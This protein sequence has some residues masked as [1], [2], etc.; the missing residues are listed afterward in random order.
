MKNKETGALAIE[1]VLSLT[2]FML[3]VIS[4]MFMA[5]II[6][7]QANMQYALS[8]TAKEISGYF[9]LVDKIGLT[10]VLSGAS[11][12]EVNEQVAEVNETI[13]NFSVLISNTEDLGSSIVSADD[14]TD[15]EGI[16][17]QTID[18]KDKAE[19]LGGQ[20]IEDIKNGE[21]KNQVIAV[22]KVFAKTMINKGFSYYVTPYVCKAL[23]PKYLTSGNINDYCAS[24][25]LKWNQNYDEG[26]E[27][28]MDFSGSQLLLDGRSVKLDVVYTINTKPLTFGLV[29]TNIAFHQC[30]TTAAWIKP[31]GGSLK[32]LTEVYR[33]NNLV[34]PTKP[35]GS[36]DEGEIAEE[37]EGE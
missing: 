5:V 13:D 22:L 29:D 26:V 35:E 37:G 21:A 33:A 23:L 27:Q 14:Y 17:N 18:I 36:G 6:K 9:Y 1:T 7:V 32:T 20:L 31:N 15:L 30:A 3:S 19:A 12:D 25:G 8:Q 10:T 16:A 34:G 4:I 2:F 28:Y 11:S 24:A